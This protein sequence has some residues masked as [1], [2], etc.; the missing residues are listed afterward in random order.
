MKRSESRYVKT[1][2]FNPIERNLFVLNRVSIWTNGFH[3]WRKPKKSHPGRFL[4]CTP[5]SRIRRGRTTR[6]SLKRHRDSMKVRRRRPFFKWS[7]YGCWS[8][9]TEVW[10]YS[11][12]FVF[13]YTCLYMYICTY[14]YISWYTHGIYRQIWSTKTIPKSPYPCFISKGFAWPDV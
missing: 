12:R 6:M 8:T 14:V 3:G 11:I 4:S 1:S 9:F 2:D 5:T 10:V 7:N 13:I